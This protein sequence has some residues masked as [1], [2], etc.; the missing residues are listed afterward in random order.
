MMF[1]LSA[2]LRT[3]PEIAP[4]RSGNLEISMAKT[5][6]KILGAQQLRYRAFYEEQHVSPPTERHVREKRDFDAWDDV[7]HFF[8][9][10]DT[11]TGQIVGTYRLIQEEAARRVGGFLSHTEYDLTP[12]DTVSGKKLELGR[13]CIHPEYRTG[14]TIQLLW[15]GIAAYIQHMDISWL[16]GT[17]SFHDTDSGAFKQALSYLHHFHRAPEGYRPQA[18]KSGYIPM[19]SIAK[20]DLV[21]SEGWSQMP[22]LIKGYL[23]LGGTVGEGAFLDETMG[24]IDVCIVM[25]AKQALE[26]FLARDSLRNKIERPEEFSF[27]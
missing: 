26:K 10:E 18:L 23:K 3:L 16:L 22:P 20:E 24:C 9:V 13:S 12:L 6:E 15:R 4:I 25:D 5:P 8:V 2:Q 11:T 17:A 14:G 19:N 21:M 7:S 27:S 1:D